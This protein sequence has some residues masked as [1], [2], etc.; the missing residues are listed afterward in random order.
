MHPFPTR[1]VIAG[2]SGNTGATKG[3][4]RDYFARLFP[5]KKVRIDGVF[6]EFVAS[7]GGSYACGNLLCVAMQAEPG[8]T[9]DHILEE[10]ALRE[11]D[12][13]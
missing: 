4:L 12:S 10:I 8:E 6:E 3:D 13:P 11:I 5:D 9:D 7:I 1:F 2:S